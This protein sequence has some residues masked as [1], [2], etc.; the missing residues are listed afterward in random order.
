MNNFVKLPNKV[1]W[2]DGNNL[3]KE[4]KSPLLPS[5]LI[6]LEGFVNNRGKCVFT[7]EDLIIDCGLLPKRGEGK[8]IEKFKSLLLDLQLQGVI[9]YD[10]DFLNI[11]SKD[12]IICKYYGFETDDEFFPISYEDYDDIKGNTNDVNIF[13]YINSRFNHAYEHPYCYPSMKTISEDLGIEVKT[14]NSS[15]KRLSDKNK[16]Y[17]ENIGYLNGNKK[18]CVNVYATT[19]KGL[20]IGLEFS[21]EH[22]IKEI[23]DENIVFNK[24]VYQ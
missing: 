19:E 7:L 3:I 5:L 2:S 22:Y 4:Y 18:E 11:K 10:G 17:Y 23:G 24:K 8:S 12:C 20:E 1:V 6:S 9:E 15:L 14:V 21:K 13:C 16:I